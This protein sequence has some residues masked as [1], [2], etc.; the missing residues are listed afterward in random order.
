[1][2]LADHRS[3]APG[4]TP[5]GPAPAPLPV[6]VEPAAAV[7]PPAAATGP[8][9]V[10]GV[11]TYASAPPHWPA[12]PA[13]SGRTTG[14]Q[15][16]AVAFALAWIA[17]PAVEPMPTGEVH[18]ALWQLPIDLAAVGSIVAAVVALWRG[19]RYAA[20][21]GLVAGALM[22]VMTIICPLAGHTPVGWWTWVQAGLSLFVMASSAAL[23]RRTA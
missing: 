9:E 2:S 6:P 20:R 15:A 4:T 16:L 18:Y 8:A 23:H 17:C 7:V 3:A 14:Q 13:R 21:L 11:A 19:S 5:A 1:M 10:A 22:A 12:P